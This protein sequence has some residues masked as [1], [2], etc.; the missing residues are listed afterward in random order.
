MWS[1]AFVLAVHRSRALRRALVR[2]AHAAAVAAV[3]GPL[4][5][6]VMSLV[7]IPLATGR[8]PGFGFRWWVQIVAH[9]PFVFTARRTLGVA[10]DHGVRTVGRR[11]GLRRRS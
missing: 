8:L 11:A 5:W 4:I 1:A 7:V 2:P 10:I 9:V 3:Y 6:F